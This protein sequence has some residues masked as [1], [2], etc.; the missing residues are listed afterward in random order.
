M[1][2]KGY[3]CVYCIQ[4]S[5]QAFGHLSSS[6]AVEVLKRKFCNY[7]LMTFLNSFEQ[8][9]FTDNIGDIWQISFSG[10]T[11]DILWVSFTG[12]SHDFTA[13]IDD[14]LRIAQFHFAED[15]HV[16]I[17]PRLLGDDLQLHSSERR[18]YL[19]QLRDNLGREE[20]EEEEEFCVSVFSV[21]KE[22]LAAKPEDREFFYN[23]RCNVY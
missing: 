20:E 1:M 13:I 8:R 16:P 6:S 7:F 3:L 18:C 15:D 12:I 19:F 21:P 4:H 11:D 22:L 9:S 17:K 14:I 10:I 2:L 5:A 23:K